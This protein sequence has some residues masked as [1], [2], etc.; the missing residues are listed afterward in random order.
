MKFKK[1]IRIF[2]PL[3]TL[4]LFFCVKHQKD[5]I[6]FDQVHKTMQEFVDACNEGNV[7]KVIE[8]FT[9]D[10]FLL[11]PNTEMIRGKQAVSD[12]LKNESQWNVKININNVEIGGSGDTAYQIAKFTITIPQEDKEPIVLKNKG[13]YVWKKQPDGSWKLHVDSWNSSMPTQS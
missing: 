10:G 11:L 5:K 13:T 6:N 2:I 1:N 12:Y 9:D 8:M 3:L 4:I 7:D